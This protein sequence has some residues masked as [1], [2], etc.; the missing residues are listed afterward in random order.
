VLS[1]GQSVHLP[2]P[3]AATRRLAAQWVVRTSLNIGRRSAASDLVH[4]GCKARMH[5]QRRP[6]AGA[7]S[8]RAPHCATQSLAGE[9]RHG[10]VNRCTWQD[11]SPP[12]TCRCRS[13][14]SCA[15]SPA[16]VSLIEAMARGL[17]PRCTGRPSAAG[18]LERWAAEKMH[19]L[20]SS[21]ASSRATPKAAPWPR[22][23]KRARVHVKFAQGWRHRRQPVTSH[24]VT[25]PAA[26]SSC[27]PASTPALERSQSSNQRRLRRR[28]QMLFSCWAPPRN[29]GRAA[30]SSNDITRGGEVRAGGRF[31]A[32]RLRCCG[33]TLRSSGRPTAAA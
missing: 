7:S 20:P 25:P 10:I 24:R 9:A 17:T 6:Y 16:W 23:R 22:H 11:P 28:A 4:I 14:H 2:P 3:Q 5:S 32:P 1:A 27:T 8:R 26:A 29:L 31:P 15:C 21:L 13:N 19:S 33:P 12:P 18:E 30:R